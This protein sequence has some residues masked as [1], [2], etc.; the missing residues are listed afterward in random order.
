MNITLS[1]RAMQKVQDTPNFGKDDI[2]MAVEN[3]EK[4]EQGEAT[5]VAWKDDLTSMEMTVKML[6]NEVRWF[7]E[8]VSDAK[9]I[10]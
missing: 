9:D 1:N 6:G 7:M 10:F 4:I 3:G 2:A 5:Y 8:D